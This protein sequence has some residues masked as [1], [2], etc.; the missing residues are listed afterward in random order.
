MFRREACERCAY[1]VAPTRTEVL[2][3]CHR[4]PPYGGRFPLVPFREWCGEW[5]D[6]Q[7]G[8][9]NGARDATCRIE[10]SDGRGGDSR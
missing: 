8:A 9:G 5:A 6:A 2:G 1:Y 4:F 10:A 7:A 3:T